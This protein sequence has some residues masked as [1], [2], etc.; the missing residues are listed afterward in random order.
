MLASE[1]V[2]FWGGNP[3][4][5]GLVF[6]IA[7]A[8]WYFGWLAIGRCCARCWRFFVMQKRTLGQ[9]HGQPSI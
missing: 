7:A 9:G 8:G 4:G 6:L 2:F 5:L 3:M 1:A